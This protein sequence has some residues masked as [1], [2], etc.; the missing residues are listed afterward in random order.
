MPGRAERVAH[1]VQAVEARN[2]VVRAA[3][4]RLRRRDLEPHPVIQALLGDLFPFCT[5]LPGAERVKGEADHADAAPAAGG[6][7]ILGACWR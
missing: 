7:G 5:R 6:P 4:E 2:Q 1:I 3:V